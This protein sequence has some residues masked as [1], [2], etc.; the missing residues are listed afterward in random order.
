M[1]YKHYF[2]DVSHL[3]HIDVYR[4][5]D[6]FSV[7]DP[8]LGHA[9]KK[10]L[11]AGIRGAKDQAKDV[12]EA[13][14]TLTRWQE[15]QKEN[16][17]IPDAGKMVWEDKELPSSGIYADESQYTAQDMQAASLAHDAELDPALVE[18]CSKTEHHADDDGWIEHH[19]N[20]CPVSDSGTLVDLKIRYGDIHRRCY[21]G[22]VYW[23]QKSSITDVIAWRYHKGE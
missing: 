16:N 8:A 2:K 11:C 23:K 17:N 18:L 22:F 6:L 20:E 7:T 21:A 3:T 19:G 4:V 15:M 10:I 14:D 9:A 13:I 1:K 12:Q 5:L